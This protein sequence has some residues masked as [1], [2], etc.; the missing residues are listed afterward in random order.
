[1]ATVEFFPPPRLSGPFPVLLKSH[2]LCPAPPAPTGPRR[3]PPAPAGP[4]SP[5]GPHRLG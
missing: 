1:M 5:T 3:A 2:Y 4:H